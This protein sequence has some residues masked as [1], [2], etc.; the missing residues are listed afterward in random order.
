ML[1]YETLILSNTHITKDEFL[2][3]E[4][5]FDKITAAV[6]GK[7]KSFDK[8]G[9]FSLA[10][11]IQKNDYGFYTLIR[12][13]IPEGKAPQIFKELDSFFRIKCNE[14][15]LRHVTKK[16]DPSIS[17]EYKKPESVD[18]RSGNLDTF[19]KE[20]KIDNFLDSDYSKNE[21]KKET[22]AVEEEN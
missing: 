3:V 19:L 17:L 22:S 10:Y 8:W 12:Y 18:S 14:I 5:Y 13:E 1:L 9:K 20:N 16:L 4:D 7:I 11:P 21:H 6:G 2:M 15:V